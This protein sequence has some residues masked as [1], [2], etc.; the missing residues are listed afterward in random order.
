[1]KPQCNSKKL[2]IQ[3]LEFG[4]S[5]THTKCIQKFWIWVK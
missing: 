1:M 2:G 5:Q 3:I 4:Y